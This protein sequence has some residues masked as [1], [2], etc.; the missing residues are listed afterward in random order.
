MEHSKILQEKNAAQQQKM[1]RLC[2]KMV[3]V[4][5]LV[6]FESVDDDIVTVSATNQPVIMKVESVESASSSATEYDD[7]N[8]VLLP[9]DVCN[10]CD[11]K[12]CSSSSLKRHMMLH[13]IPTYQCP[14][15]PQK[16]ARKDYVQRHYKRVHRNDGRVSTQ[17]DISIRQARHTRSNN[18]TL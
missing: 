13:E 14:K 10:E 18:A 6:S 15:C 16:F 7:T 9:V 8:S 11:K 1:A 17:S 5:Q 3:A 2:S 4:Q 12:F